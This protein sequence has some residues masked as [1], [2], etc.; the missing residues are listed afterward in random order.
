M[1]VHLFLDADDAGRK[2]VSASVR[3]LWSRAK[4]LGRDFYLDTV[5]PA[6]QSAYG[7]HDPD[8]F[9]KE[10][11]SR[12]EAVAF[13]ERATLP[14]LTF[15]AANECSCPAEDLE[16]AWSQAPQI[17]RLSCLRSIDRLGGADLWGYVLN[18]L[19]PDQSFFGQ[20]S[21]AKGEWA[22]V[23]RNFLL[24]GTSGEPAEKPMRPREAEVETVS[25]VQLNH[26]LK[27]ARASTQRRDIPIDEGGWNRM[28]LASD[29]FLRHFGFVLGLGKWHEEPFTAVKVPKQDGEF[30]LKALPCQE[31][32]VLQQYLIDEILRDHTQGPRFLNFIPA[33]RHWAFPK[34]S[35]S[36]TT[37][38]PELLPVIE[39]GDPD[40]VSF[41][42]Q[43]D[44]D[45]LEG[46]TPPTNSGMFRPYYQ[47]WKDFIAF[48]D[49]KVGLITQD[50]L[51]VARLDIRR[52]YDHL[53]RFAVRDALLK[54]LQAALRQLP[55]PGACAP[56]F[57][58]K[59]TRPDERACAIV[60]SLCD[61]SFGYLYYDPNDGRSKRY[62][63]QDR[64]IP[65][66]PDLSAYLANVSLFKLDRAVTQRVDSLNK[67]Y[68]R[69]VAKLRS[70]KVS[71]AG[72]FRS[73]L[74]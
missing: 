34:G 44:M 3:Q 16:T 68:K 58:P 49:K 33:V 6:A 36:A 19:F 29:V 13:L 11:V 4:E 70:S 20:R 65:Q 52:F 32:L 8:E 12:E 18:R 31:D 55:N 7:K 41:A 17:V 71:G 27:L 61:V 69:N 38:I 45:V 74:H 47:C 56:A 23:L 60:D 43:V 15:L 14:A 73:I 24:S 1:C 2:G 35:K 5:S 25:E 26:A 28:D 64:G 63:W 42:Y 37:G 21:H 51:Y 50:K 53:P 22:T 48:I 10:V 46:R 9:L 67:G 62:P 39:E 54:P 66:G 72:T 40:V 57:L 30:R 59:E